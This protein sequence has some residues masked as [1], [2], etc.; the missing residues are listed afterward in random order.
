ME[1]ENPWLVEENRLPWD[2]D[3]SVVR[4]RECTCF[5]LRSIISPYTVGDSDE[6]S[7]AA[8]FGPLHP[9]PGPR[10]STPPPKKKHRPSAF[11]PQ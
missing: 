2:Q 3:V 8:C 5:G 4:F 11:Y 6:V 7:S 9:I 1:P 10:E